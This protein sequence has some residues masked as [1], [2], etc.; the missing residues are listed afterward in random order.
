MHCPYNLTEP[1]SVDITHWLLLPT[2][3]YAILITHASFG[4]NSIA[5]FF[6]SHWKFSVPV[7]RLIWFGAGARGHQTWRTAC[8]YS[9]RREGLTCSHWPIRAI[10]WFLATFRV[11]CSNRFNGNFDKVA[12]IEVLTWEQNTLSSAVISVS[13][14][15]LCKTHKQSWHHSNKLVKNVFFALVWHNRVILCLH[16][17]RVNYCVKTP[18]V[19]KRTTIEPNNS[20]S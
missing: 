19:K 20:F 11:R 10:D 15:M 8:F 5:I 7:W 9:L 6:L 17:F 3:R 16:C 1:L 4:L 18:Q 13:H 12:E 2:N 14:S